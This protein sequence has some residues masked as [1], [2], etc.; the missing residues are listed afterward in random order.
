MIS[1]VTAGRPSVQARA[2]WAAET[3]RSWPMPIRTSTMS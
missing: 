2:I 3:P 1:E